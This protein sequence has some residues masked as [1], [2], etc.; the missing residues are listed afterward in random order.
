VAFG[1]LSAVSEA[2][3]DFRS[4]GEI[5]TAGLAISSCYL[6]WRSDAAVAALALGDTNVARR[7][8]DEE[9]DWPARSG[10]R[11]RSGWHCTQP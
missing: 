6:P 7:F 4:A 11:V 1:S 9:L 8:S 3:D 10:L 2:F 5:A